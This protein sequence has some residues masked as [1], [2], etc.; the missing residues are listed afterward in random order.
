MKNLLWLDDLRNPFLDEE[1]RVPK[2][3][4]QWNIN[5]VLNHDQFV[6]W[7]EMYGVP[8]AISFDH[9]LAEEHYTPEYF[10]NDY[11]ESKKFQEWK[12]KTHKFKTGEY[13]AKWLKIHCYELG[14]HLPDIYV[15]S[16]NPVGADKIKKVFSL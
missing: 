5:W 11:E 10:W 13:C 2:G 1:K 16:A 4:D 14:F 15:H 3:N 7:I 12:S 8:D 6:K 9:D